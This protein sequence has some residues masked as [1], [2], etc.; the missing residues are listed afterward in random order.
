MYLLG[1]SPAQ[2]TTGSLVVVGVTALVGALAAHRA[3]HV[4]LG[5]GLVF[6][7]TATGGAVLGAHA[8]TRVPE[9]VLLAAFSA[10]MLVVGTGL[11]VRQWHGRNGEGPGRRRHRLDEPILV[12][13]PSFSCHCPRAVQVLVG[14]TVVGLL[15][16][17]LG[18]G[19]GFLVVPVLLV[20][21]S[22]PLEL[23]TGT[24]LVAITV[25]SGAAL[26]AR[27]GVATAPDWRP[28]LAL[29]GAAAVGA[30]AGTYLGSRTD[31]RRLTAALTG[32][33]LTVAAFTVI[34]AL[35]AVA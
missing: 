30:V 22:M 11:A 24:S 13:R 35:P 16:G 8:S 15:T 20:A 2:A 26:L 23:A 12:L 18:V 7:L 4:L 19:G 17:F 6:G 32:L 5:R 10:L 3:G 9:P 29:T 21:F 14:A 25:T 1:Q 33:V 31:P 34:H 28:V 27:T